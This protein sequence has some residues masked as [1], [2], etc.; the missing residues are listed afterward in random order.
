MGRGGGRRLSEP[1]TTFALND[2]RGPAPFWPVNANTIASAANFMAGGAG[3]RDHPR[4]RR[5]RL[6]E[7]L[8]PGL[9]PRPRVR[10]RVTAGPAQRIREEHENAR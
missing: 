1:T 8:R 5:R 4:H 2:I 9:C 6:G 7:H 3:R 10:R